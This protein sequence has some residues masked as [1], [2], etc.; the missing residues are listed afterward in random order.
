[1][2][3][4]RRPGPVLRLLNPLAVGFVGMLGLAP[5]GLMVLRVRRRVSGGIQ[6]VPLNVLVH[7]GAYHLVSLHGESDWLRNLRAAGRATLVR[8]RTIV[9]VEVGEELP[10]AERIP[11]LRAYLQRWDGQLGAAFGLDRLSSD[12]DLREAA[13]RTPIVRLKLAA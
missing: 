6:R 13:A 2:V 1:M 11:A 12:E 9:P 10:E 8:G 7:Q 3:A 5:A 4:R